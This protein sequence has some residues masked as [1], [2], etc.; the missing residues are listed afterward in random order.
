MILSCT[1][2]DFE[3]PSVFCD[4]GASVCCEGS[5]FHTQYAV[6]KVYPSFVFHPATRHKH[7]NYPC[8]QKGTL[9]SD[10]N[11]SDLRS[12]FLLLRLKN[13]SN[14]TPET[15]LPCV[16]PPALV[17]FIA[18][19][20][21][22]FINFTNQLNLQIIKW[23]RGHA[24]WREFFSVHTTALMPIFNTRAASL[25]SALFMARSTIC[26]FMPCWQARYSYSSWKLRQHAWL[27]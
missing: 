27:R 2:A 10:S 25:I 26:V 9:K 20:W 8:N 7:W 16:P 13:M 21:P 23:Q 1:F 17:L 5:G 24:P 4:S 12:V 15:W 18:D 6:C 14:N 22:H 19:K 11:P 3:Y